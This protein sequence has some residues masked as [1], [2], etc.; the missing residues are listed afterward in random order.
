MMTGRDDDDDV[1][2][3]DGLGRRTW[4]A[5]CI[6]ARVCVQV[7]SRARAVRQRHKAAGT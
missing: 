2:Y 6:R 5:A 4:C 3:S 1:D 7:A